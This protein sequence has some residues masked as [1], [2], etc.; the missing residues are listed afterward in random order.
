[1]KELIANKTQSNKLCAII[2]F[3]IVISNTIEPS[4]NKMRLTIDVVNNTDL[5]NIETLILCITISIK[6][7][8]EIKDT[9][10]AKIR[11]R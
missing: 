4:Q 8:I 1:M 10:Q 11:V 3:L 6:L 7:K 2:R 9:L 5:L